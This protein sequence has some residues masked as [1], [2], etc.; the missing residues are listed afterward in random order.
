MATLEENFE[1][2]IERWYLA[3]RVKPHYNAYLLALNTELESHEE[4]WNLAKHCFTCGIKFLCDPRNKGRHDLCCP[5]GCRGVR[6]RR[7]G[8]ERSMRYYQSYDGK[9]NKKDLNARAYLLGLKKPKPPPVYREKFRFR[10]SF[11]LYLRKIILLL[12]RK[13][14]GFKEIEELLLKKIRQRGIALKSREAYLVESELKHSEN[15]KYQRHPD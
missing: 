14:M 3:E 5:Y 1:H 8:N 12:D 10:H 6:K 4:Y 13:L 2:T 9:Q 15:E 7:K 11:L